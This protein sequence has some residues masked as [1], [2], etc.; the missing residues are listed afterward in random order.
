[1]DRRELSQHSNVVRRHQS[2]AWWCLMSGN[3][4]E[5]LSPQ[6]SRPSTWNR[7]ELT[8]CLGAYQPFAIN[9][10]EVIGLLMKPCVRHSSSY[11]PP[12][13]RRCPPS[14]PC[15]S[16]SVF[17]PVNLPP[18]HFFF[19]FL[20]LHLPPPPPP[21][22]SSP[23]S[24]LSP[25]PALAHSPHLPPTIGACAPATRSCARV[26]ACVSHTGAALRGS[27]KARPSRC[28]S[29]GAGSEADGCCCSRWLYLLGGNEV[30]RARLQR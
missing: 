20:P 30:M 28:G 1:M 29:R 6:G 23:S 27:S 9:P 14:S 2:S 8:K 10:D 13:H 11:L 25:Q 16:F 24:S 12:P 17:S 19:F 26:C 4:N 3:S 15:D 5:L 22:R 18:T 7:A 21:T